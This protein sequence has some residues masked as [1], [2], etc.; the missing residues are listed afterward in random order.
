MASAPNLEREYNTIAT[1]KKWPKRTKAAL[2]ARLERLGQSRYDSSNG[3]MTRS[4][5]LKALGLSENNAFS[6][7]AWVANGL[8]VYKEENGFQRVFIGD[9]IK[10]CLSPSG[11]PYAAKFLSKNQ[12]VAAWFLAA[13]NDW[14]LENP[15][16]KKVRNK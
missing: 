3:W 8:P 11:Q 4:Q 5:L 6:F 16:N 7:S 13:I 15:S 10:W 14:L 1:S 9:F 12:S 2:I